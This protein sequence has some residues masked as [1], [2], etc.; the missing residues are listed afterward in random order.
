[1]GSSDQ[2]IMSFISSEFIMKRLILIG[3]LMTCSTVVSAHGGGDNVYRETLACGAEGCAVTCYQPGDRWQSF[4]Q[5]AGD[6]EVTY[7]I[8]TGV[9][10]LKAKVADGSYTVLDTHPQFQSCRITGVA[11]KTKE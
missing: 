11:T 9:R 1:M 5:T 6:I 10:Q 8:H 2:R 4:L 3:L 7:F